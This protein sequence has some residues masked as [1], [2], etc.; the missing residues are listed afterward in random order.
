M[1]TKNKKQ[2]KFNT[3][4]IL[5]A[6]KPMWL[7]LYKKTVYAFVK[8]GDNILSD[9]KE[10]NTVT[11]FYDKYRNTVV[12]LTPK[13]PYNQEE[14]RVFMTFVDLTPKIIGKEFIYRVINRVR[15]DTLKDAESLFLSKYYKLV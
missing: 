5:I 14:K 15:P 6:Y 12:A 1:K 2:N 13:K 10:A 4:D 3:G 11:S 9:K 8:D 7:G